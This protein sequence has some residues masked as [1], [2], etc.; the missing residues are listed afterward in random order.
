MTPVPGLE[1]VMDN[2][3]ETLP[4]A[5]VLCRKLSMPMFGPSVASS[6]SVTLRAGRVPRALTAVTGTSVVVPMG[7]TTEGAAV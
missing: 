5:A 1:G 4:P 6:I 3:P 2:T 7:M